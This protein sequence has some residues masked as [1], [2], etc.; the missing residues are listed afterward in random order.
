MLLHNL[1]CFLKS[2]WKAKKNLIE[3]IF[4]KTETIKLKRKVYFFT[5]KQLNNIKI[6]NFS[7]SL[8]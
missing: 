8:S 5:K 2:N 4:D 7:F 6:S 3:K 1:F